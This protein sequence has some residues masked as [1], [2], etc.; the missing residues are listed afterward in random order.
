MSRAVDE[1]DAVA[2]VQLTTKPVGGGDAADA[3]TD[4]QHGLGCGR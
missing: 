2:A 1:H 4:H 3:A